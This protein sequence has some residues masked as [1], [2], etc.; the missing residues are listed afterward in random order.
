MPLTIGILAI[1]STA[2]LAVTAVYTARD[3]NGSAPSIDIQDFAAKVIT[4]L[5]LASENGNPGRR[6]RKVRFTAKPSRSVPGISVLGDE[7]GKK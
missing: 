1:V 3:C 4:L 2:D 6:F 5:G 7:N